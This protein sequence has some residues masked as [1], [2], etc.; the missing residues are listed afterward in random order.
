MAGGR[1]GGLCLGEGRGVRAHRATTD[2]V[3]VIHLK[4]RGH[5]LLAVDR[6]R[7]GLSAGLSGRTT[8]GVV[9]V[10]RHSNPRAQSRLDCGLSVAAQRAQCVLSSDVSGGEGWKRAR[11]G[12][13]TEGCR[14]GGGKIPVPR[15]RRGWRFSRVFEREN[16]KIQAH[17]DIGV[18]R[19]FFSTNL[20]SFLRSILSFFL[21]VNVQVSHR[22]SA[23]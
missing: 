11:R 4:G 13:Y 6:R 3:E 2:A 18:N 20:S 17:P 23:R 10:D 22:K 9:V 1:G 15:S 21:S 14:V 7:R 19:V 5:T 12:E 16:V 8:R